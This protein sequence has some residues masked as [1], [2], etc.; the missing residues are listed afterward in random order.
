[1]KR[2]S[3]A[4]RYLV[5]IG[6]EVTSKLCV[7]A[8]FAYL[9]RVLGPRGFG[10]VELALSTTML[11]VLGTELGMTVHGA[12]IVETSPDRA[13][14]LVPRAGLLRLMLAAP[15]CLAML[16]LSTLPGAGASGLLAVYSLVVLL[17]PFNTQWVFQG[18]RQM[19]WVAVGSLL[20]Y[21]TFA[22]AVL[23]LVRQ[24]SDLRIVALAEVAGALVFAAFNSAM[25]GRVLRIRL[26]WSAV[27]RGAAGLLR[28]VWF[29]GASELAWIATW[30]TPTIIIGWIDPSRTEQVAWIAAAV[31]IVMAL[32][33]FVW[34]YF[35]NMVP[36]LARER[37]AG[38]EAWRG[39]LRRSLSL[40][41]WFGCF[42]AVMG[43]LLAPLV[44]TTLFGEAYQPAALPL[45]IVV[46]MIPVL[47]VSG[48]FRYSLI[49]DGRQH[50]DLLA[51]VAG[52]ATTVLVTAMAGP[53]YGA[54]GGAAAILSAGV[55]NA[56]VSG[57][58]MFRVTGSVR[59]GVLMPGVLTAVVALVAGLVLSDRAGWGAGAAA[60]FATYAVVVGPRLSPRRVRDAWEG[61]S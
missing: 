31:R 44:V 23:L 29:I 3:F 9:A 16:W 6:G 35:F 61:R 41:I 57:A 4:V 10:E 11:F 34:L 15:A 47:W 51:S 50:L 7:L 14:Q 53:V 2:R 39:L 5:L 60:A 26:D 52:A 45:Q 36:N 24:G 18:L 56:C 19:Q 54:A 46:W 37:H 48:H 28:D 55:V 25:L 17:T 8:A 33:T 49:A 13:A 58:A 40:S 43:T 22:A 1:L 32:H 12:R 30:L 27:W 42:V 20:R 21:G 38:L 59:L